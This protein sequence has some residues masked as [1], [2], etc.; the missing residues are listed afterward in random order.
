LFLS[1]V[2]DSEN[3]KREGKIPVDMDGELIR[4]ALIFKVFI[5]ISS[6]PQEFFD[7]KGKAI[8]IQAM[9]VPEG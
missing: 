7:C 1:P 3:F 2:L 4:G 6:Y 9:R 5:E 8:H